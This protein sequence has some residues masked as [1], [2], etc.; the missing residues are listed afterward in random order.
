[1]DVVV[2]RVAMPDDDELGPAKPHLADVTRGDGVPSPVVQCLAQRQRQ[3][4]V[5][6]RAF[7][8]GPELP[9]LA[10]L[11]GEVSRVVADHVAADELCP[12]FAQEIVERPAKAA[13]LRLLADHAMAAPVASGADGNMRVNESTRS[14][15]GRSCANR[16]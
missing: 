12:V 5:V 13:T 16:R 2:L 10:E 9:H 11:G 8:L 1:M 15:P 14:E 3:T 7:E 6:D 4:R